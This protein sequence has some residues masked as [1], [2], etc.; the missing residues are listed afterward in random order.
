VDDFRA[1]LSDTAAASERWLAEHDAKIIEEV[2]QATVT[3]AIGQVPEPMRSAVVRVLLNDSD[4]LAAERA[5]GAAEERSRLQPAIDAVLA[6][7]AGIGGKPATDADLLEG[8]AILLDGVDDATDE[9]FRKAGKDR[10]PGS[11]GIQNALRELA[12][13][14]PDAV[15]K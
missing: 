11:R 7:Y 14:L 6:V 3:V 4:L 2:A 9:M 12:A 15:S 1:L 10:T 13:S 5:K 8:V